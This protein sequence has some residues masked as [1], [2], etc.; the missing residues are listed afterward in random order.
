M[1]RRKVFNGIR[2]FQRNFP[3]LQTSKDIEE[4]EKE[5]HQFRKDMA[6]A[7]K[8][9][10]V[11]ELEKVLSDYFAGGE[12]KRMAEQKGIRPPEDYQKYLTFVELKDLK[13]GVQYDP[14]TGKEIPILND[15]GNQVKYRSM[16]EAYIVK[17]YKRELEEAR[18]RSSKEIAKKLSEANSG[19]VQL[20]SDYV[21]P[22]VTGMTVDQERAILK[23]HPREY[24]NDPQKFELVKKFYNNLGL[25]V[26]QYRGRKN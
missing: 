7:T 2:E 21:G 1:S 22:A 3:E 20:P 8:V 23:M 12:H 4:I 16:E 6:R 18:K 10:S 24:M 19:A 25:D 15:E 17:N 13:N 26:P 9:S 14:V 5:Y 11:Y